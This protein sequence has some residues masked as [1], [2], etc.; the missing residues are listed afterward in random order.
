MAVWGRGPL[1]R[2]ATPEVLSILGAL[3]KRNWEASSLKRVWSLTIPHPEA[4]EPAVQ[5]SALHRR[6]EG[7][8]RILEDDG[9]SSFGRGY[10]PLPSG[11]PSAKGQDAIARLLALGVTAATA[12]GDAD[13]PAQGY[14]GIGLVGGAGWVDRNALNASAKEAV[15]ANL[16]KLLKADADERHLIMWVDPTNFSGEFAMW[17]SQLPTEVPTFDDRVKAV[18]AA[19][20]GPHVSYGSNAARL[21]RAS[22]PGDGR[23]L[24]CQRCDVYRP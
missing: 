22:P 11:E 24:T 9:V 6:V 7:L 21:W 14:I 16:A 17:D 4:G 8:L 18:W 20:W 13:P 1:R 2:V 15:D 23:S 5:I 12:V 19:I 10:V 3:G